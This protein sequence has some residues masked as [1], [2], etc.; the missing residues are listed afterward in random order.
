MRALAGGD[1]ACHRGLNGRSD[2]GES[3]SSKWLCPKPPTMFH[4]F[5][6]GKRK[7]LSLTILDSVPIN[8]SLFDYL[9]QK[10]SANCLKI[11]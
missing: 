8:A 4:V 5:C 7:I 9:L 2:A 10:S 11:L 6:W 1:A 3:C